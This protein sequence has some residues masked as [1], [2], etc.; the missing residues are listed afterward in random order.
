VKR[1][2]VYLARLDPVE[3]S[4]QAGRRPVILVSRDAINAASP[5]VVVV[6]CTSYDERRRIYPSQVVLRAP[7]AG[8]RNDSIAL[9]EQVRSVAKQR[10]V[11]RWGALD[12]VTMKNLDR[13]LLITLDLPG[14]TSLCG[15]SPRPRAPP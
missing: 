13:A 12:P 14:S 1:G 6:P 8:L 5:V 15:S 11:E 9:G 3:G 2:D 7:E 10:L 4:E